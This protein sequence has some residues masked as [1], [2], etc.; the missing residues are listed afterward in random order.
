MRHAAFCCLLGFVVGCDRP[1]GPEPV[2][3]GHLATAATRDDEARGVELA[4]ADV[5]A[6]GPVL[7]VREAPAGPTPE[8]AA[9]QGTRLF[10]LNKVRGLI[11]PGTATAADRVRAQA[12]G[13]VVVALS[14]WTGSPPAANLF[15]L[16]VAPAERGRVL[17]LTAKQILGGKAGK[18][19]VVRDPAAVSAGAAADRFARDCGAFAAVT[20]SRPGVRPADAGVVFF[21][22]PAAVAL[23]HRGLYPAAAL[24][25]GDEEAELPALQPGGDGFVFVTPYDLTATTGFANRY[26]DKYQREPT[27]A[28]ALAYDALTLWAEVGR[29]A[30]GFDPAAVRAELLKRETPFESLSGP[31]TFAD[32]HTARRKVFVTRT[33]DGRRTTE[34]YD[35]EPAK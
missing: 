34:A 7:R 17:A 31:L 19:L 30:N 23:E 29:R 33:K 25:F 32:D 11:G 28:A 4:L 21:A 26:R 35:P 13:G 3:L 10:A 6:S 8:A 16:G 14:G 24:L 18:V 15:G 27:V 20:E 2:E 12:E 5:N 1:A 22:T 9:A